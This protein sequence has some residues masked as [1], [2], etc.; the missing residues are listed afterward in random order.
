M[1]QEW[2]KNFSD[3]Q[4][5]VRSLWLLLNLLGSLTYLYIH[6]F[7]HICIYMSACI[8]EK[9]FLRR[10]PNKSDCRPINNSDRREK[11]L[12][13]LSHS[14]S[15]FIYF[16]V[17]DIPVYFV[18]VWIIHAGH[19][20]GGIFHIACSILEFKSDFQGTRARQ[21]QGTWQRVS[22]KARHM[23]IKYGSYIF[24][25]FKADATEYSTV[26]WSVFKTN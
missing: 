5:F 17:P 21:G 6:P 15:I 4:F 25:K 18:V 10:I 14:A 19:S 13:F 12:T 23:I 8:W 22:F 1:L 7:P 20:V 3:K 9:H 16:C 26:S 24:K 11:F 2:C